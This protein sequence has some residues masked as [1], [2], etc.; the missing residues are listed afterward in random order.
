MADS[1]ATAGAGGVAGGAQAP[2]PSRQG[3]RPARAAVSAFAPGQEVLAWH[4]NLS[5][6]PATVAQLRDD[7]K[8]LLN[9][10]DGEESDRVKTRTNLRKGV[11]DQMKSAKALTPRV[12]ESRGIILRDD[13]AG[14]AAPPVAGEGGAEGGLA[15]D[16]AVKVGEGE[17]V[18][19]GGEVFGGGAEPGSVAG[20]AGS[21]DHVA[22]LKDQDLL[23]SS[24]R[25]KRRSLDSEDAPG[26]S[27][28]E[29]MAGSKGAVPPPLNAGGWQKSEHKGLLSTWFQHK[30]WYHCELCD[31]LNDR[32]YHSKMHYERM[33]VF[34]KRLKLLTLLK[35]F[36]LSPCLS[37][38]AAGMGGALSHSQAT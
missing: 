35:P 34:L 10:A 21:A 28:A 32:L 5:W 30:R 38:C 13:G 3:G 26:E 8:Y 1:A 2:Q 20:G 31:Y 4:R 29:I 33:C 18:I 16:G 11:K 27:Q 24:K 9:W 19:S 6:K 15:S 22:H 14:L 37:R 36:H 7:G 23:A 25:D 12:S 17:V